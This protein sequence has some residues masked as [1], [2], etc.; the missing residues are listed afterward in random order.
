MR[1]KAGPYLSDAIAPF[2]SSFALLRIRSLR[3][4]RPTAPSLRRAALSRV[5]CV[6]R[7][8]VPRAALSSPRSRPS[9]AALRWISWLASWAW[10]YLVSSKR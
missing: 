2:C 9:V 3:S 5:A 4:L 10:I 8:V 1:W 6:A 7:L